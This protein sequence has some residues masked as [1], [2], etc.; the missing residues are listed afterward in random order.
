MAV[1]LTE[2]QIQEWADNVNKM[3][4]TKTW[5]VEGKSAEEI[6]E[7]GDK[8]L[9]FRQSKMGTPEGRTE[10]M[11]MMAEMFNGINGGEPLDTAQIVSMSTHM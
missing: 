4:E 1:E 9:A 2:A 5:S 7:A 8:L 6:K 11:G 3:H 10:M